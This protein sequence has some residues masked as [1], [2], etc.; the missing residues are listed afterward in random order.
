MAVRS[1][2]LRFSTKNK[3]IRTI[4]KAS[5]AIACEL[6]EDRR[7]LT[8]LGVNL[9]GDFPQVLVGGGGQ[10]QYQSTTFTLNAQDLSL[11]EGIAFGPSG[12]ALVTDPI[13]ADATGSNASLLKIT[14]ISDPTIS[15]P[16]GGLLTGGVPVDPAGDN[17]IIQGH[18][19]TQLGVSTYDGVLLT[20]KIK[21]F[22]SNFTDSSAG[23][24]MG[25]FDFRFEAT[26]GLLYSRYFAGKDIG[27]TL[28]AGDKAVG[29]TYPASGFGSGFISNVP[30]A[31][32]AP[33]TP[34]NTPPAAAIHL[35]KLTNGTDNDSPT[36]PHVPVGST[37]TW[38]YVVTNTGSVPLTNINVTDDHFGVTPVYVGG[39]SNNNSI[40]DLTETWTYRATGIAIAG[41]YRNV[42]TVTGTIP[43]TNGQTVTSNNPDHYF[44]DL[45]K[46]KI[47]K[48]TNDT[49]NDSPTGPYISVGSPVT[50][51]YNVTNPGNVP[52]VNVNVTDSIAGV[53][54]TPTL[55]GGFNVGDTNADNRLDVGE[56][57]VYTA[58][59]VATAGQYG[60]VGTATGDDFFIPT[61]HVTDQ[62][63]DH[64]YGYL[65]VTI[66]DFVW[67]DSNANGIQDSGEPGI[68][69]VTLTLTG[70]D[71]QGNVVT[72]TA[73]T[74]G[75][76][77]YTFIE[78]PG[79]YTV[80]VDASNFTGAGALAGYI[81]SPTLQGGNPA[82]DSNPNPSG[83]T[84]L[85]FPL[86][87]GGS[88]LTIDFGYYN[89]VTI[90]NFVWN[91]LNGNGIQNPGEPGIPGVTLTL[92]GTTGSGASVTQTT[93][94]DANG[95]YQFTEPPG[96][97]TVSVTTPAGYLPT[98]T[99]Q[100]TPATDSNTTPSGT[101]P[102]TLPSG[103][104]DQTID[105]G[106]F[107]VAPAIHIVKLTNSTD[108]DATTGPFVP[109][110]STVTWT[111]N[112]TNT[113][114]V[115]LSNVVVTDD[116]GTPGNTG[117]D[118]IVGV[119][120][121]LPIGGSASLTHQGTA[122]A[123]QYG[124]VGTVTGTPVDKNGNPIPGTT[125]PTDTNPDHYFAYTTDVH[126]IKLTNGTDNDTGTGPFVPVGS[127]VTWTY[128][129]TTTGNVPL[130]NV[131]VT[132]NVAGVNP[133]PSLSGGF[134]TGDTN[135]DNLLESGETWVFTASGIAVAGQYGNVGTVTGTPVTPTG[136][137][138]PGA[139]TQTDTNPDHYFGAT[140]SIAL[141]KL[142]NGTNN[143]TG[144]GPLVPAGSTVTWTYNVTNTGNVTLVNVVVTDDNGTP[145]NTADDFTVGTIASLAPGGSASLNHSG[146]ALLG[147]YGNVGSVIGTPVDNN[148]HTIPGTT[149]PTDTNPD[150]YFAYTTNINIVKLTNGSNNDTA[151]GLYVQA[152]SP[153]TWTYNVTTTG[154]VP[155][156]NVNVTDN[157]AGV[158]PAPV[159][160]GGFNVGD[161]NHDSL[162]EIGE[163]WVFTASGT[164]I[165]GQY[166]N[167][168]TVTGTPSDTSGNPI[169][170]ASTQTATNPDNYFGA[171]P[172][173]ALVKLTNGTN[174]DTGTGPLVPVGSTVTWTYNV[175]NTGNVTLANVVV[176]DDNGTPGNTADDFT[177]G[178][179]ASLAP[180][181]SASL[182]HTGIAVAGQ[183][184]NVG[185]VIGTPVDNNGHTI[186]GTTPP[187][188]TNPDH[189][190][191][192]SPITIGDFVWVD[193]NA[194]GVQDAGE[195]GINGV[196]L[197][198]TGTDFLGNPVTD[199]RTTAGNGA[200]LFTE[201]PGTY[202]VTV[203]TANF[204]GA[205]ALTGYTATATGQ[206]T[207]A[208]DSNPNP[209]ATTPGT[210]LLPGG[211][212]DLTIDFGFY[213]PVTIGNFVWND[214]NGNG[215]QDT[216]E[217]GIPGVTLTLTGTTGSGQSVTQTTTT[218]ANGLYQFTEPPGTYTVAV[219]APSGY[220][221]TVTGQGTTAI[222]SNPSPSGTTP[223]T[224]P[225][226]GTDQTID[227]GFYKPVTIGDFVWN[228]TN[229][230]GV[231]DGGEA[232]IP[233]VTLTLTGTTGA[234]VGVSQTTTTDASGHYLFTEPPGT[235]TVAVT[236]PAGYTPTAS[237]KGT[238]ATD[239]NPT[240]SGTTPGTLPGGSSDLTI[241]FGFYQ[242]VTIGNFVW[243]DANGNGVQDAGEPGI[244]GVTLTLIGTT[245]SGQSVSQTTT[246]DANGLYQFTE[247]PGTYSVA[248]TAP[249]GYTP[250]VTGKGTTATDSNPTPSGTTPGTLP[251]GGTDQTIDFGFYKPVTIGD[252]VW[253]DTNGNGVQD[254][255]EAGIPGVTLT[256]T[257][258]TGAGA[259]V[260]QTTTIGAAGQYL[261][262]E[263]P[264]T[265]TVTVT[266]PAGYTPTATGK[267]TTATD[268]NTNPSSTTP[269]T[270]P[271][272]SSDL[273]VDFGF[274]KPVTIGDFVWTDTNANGIQDSGEAGINGVTLTLTGT[275]GAGVAVTDHA[276]TSG[277]GGYL[278]TEAPGTY[279][280]TVDASNFATGGALAGYFV[281]PTLAGT[282]RAVDSNVSPSG[283]TP[284]ALPGG[285][286]D[287]T[288]DF[289]YYKQFA[290]GI[291]TTVGIIT[292]IPA[293]IPGEFA[294][295]GFW[296][297]QN[298]QAVIKSFNGSSTSTLLGNWLA[299][300]FPHLFGASNP[301]TGTSL[302]GLTNA[303]VAQVYLNLWTPSGVT[304][305]TYVQ[306]F[307][308]ALGLY[309]DTT[310]LG[311][312]SLLNNGLA[313]QFGFVVTTSGAGSFN[314]GSNGV[315]FGVSNGSSLS[316]MQVLQI[317]DA[318]FS[319]STGL[320]FAG[321]QTKTSQFNNVTNGINSLGDIP[322]T[323]TT[324]TLTG[325]KLIDSATISGGLNPTGTV[326]FYLMAPGSTASTPLSSAV[327]TDVVTVN[328]NGTYSVAS[329]SS[330]YVPTVSGTYQWVAIYSGDAN[331]Q[332]ITSPFGSEPQTVGN[333]TTTINTIPGSAVTLGSG[334]K[335][336]DTAAL[337]AGVNA[338]GTITFYLFA[339]GVTP[340][341]TDSNNVYSDVVTVNG[342]GTYTTAAGTN[343]GGYLPTVAGTYQ[344]IAV[345]SGDANNASAS[346]NF[347][348]E[349]EVASA[350]L[351]S[352]SGNVYCDNNLNGIR[353]TGEAAEPGTVV[354]LYNG[355][356]LVATKTT[357]SSG[358]YSFTG[359][360]PGTYTVK[361]TTPSSGDVV[362]LSHGTVVI[363][364]SYTVTLAP[365]GTTS[366]G[367]NFAEIDYGSISGMIFLDNNDNAM[368]DTGDT[369]IAGATVT[370]TGTDYLGNP[371]SIPQTTSSSG[372]FSFINLLPSN[373]AGYT[374]QTTPPAGF[375]IGSDTPGTL[376]GVTTGI[377][378]CDTDG[379]V[380]NIVLPGCN[381]DAVNYN[382]GEL[383]IFHGLTA[384]IG[385]W[386]NANG[387][388][389]IKSFGTTSSGLTLANLLATNMPNL[390]GKNAP[391]WNVNSTIGTNLTGRSNTDVANY[392]L[393][394]FGVSGQKSYAQILATAFAVF[395]TTNSLNTG[396]TSRALATK[397]GFTLSNTGAGA[398]T[399]TVPQAD[400]AAFGITSSAGATQSISQL[401]LLANKYAIKGVLNNGNTTLITETSDVFNAINNLGDIG[402][403]M[404]LISSGT[405]G[406]VMTDSIGHL[407][408]GTYLVAVDGLSGDLAPAEQARIDDAI[409]NLN[410]S[411]A[412]FGVLLAEAPADLVAS[413]DIH[414][415]L[416]DTSV[417]GGLDQGVLGVTQTGGNIT[418]ING[419]N[420][421]VD[422]NAS[423]IEAN[424]FDF[425][426]V[427]THEM[428]HALGLGHSNDAGSVM[429]PE[430]GT[431]EA[432]RDLTSSDLAAIDNDG[433]EA[434]QALHAI[435]FSVKSPVALAPIKTKKAAKPQMAQRPVFAARPISQPKT[436]GSSNLAGLFS[437]TLVSTITSAK[438]PVWNA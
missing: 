149:P 2:N 84:P 207:T 112:V 421:Y 119:I 33:L 420:Y 135:H 256:L 429:Y 336:T 308:N 160:S 216:G 341:A 342:N 401:T 403:G 409:A 394:I 316:V 208:T 386:H 78:N 81:A 171:T 254:S 164:A 390:F 366:T 188:D 438:D 324:L 352:I 86:P 408:A 398:A 54:P 126:I 255:G 213:K 12:P 322:G 195:P 198:L 288:I 219:T 319:A 187:T 303:Q 345:Y 404:A 295:I 21:A 251:S 395:T 45:P 306:A 263:P 284:A 326:T 396:A 250:T 105:F 60:N 153:V 141:V 122:V 214:S 377:D 413:A 145:G 40:L 156:S 197:T 391:G 393:T 191:A 93:T 176:T 38:D 359:V 97:Y 70:T 411:A 226:G 425:Q 392:F 114:N 354:S 245:G 240:P 414:I 181:A 268:S 104:S 134:N 397:Y 101:T 41:Q 265:Y 231:Q 95:L 109:V 325:M 300:S 269:G 117:D 209:S 331:N 273:T 314:I 292:G 317:V 124:N 258:T 8:L 340:N 433:E 339:P 180:G 312:Q 28:D 333:A 318:N 7:L 305:N 39:D 64:Y 121:S 14:V 261:F 169:P 374:V 286:S 1:Q 205:G 373:S 166:S 178:T 210:F 212:S 361:V 215:V 17:L 235:Y 13:T 297:N 388:S 193:T 344:W 146:I 189:Y 99:G 185:S 125:P 337:A 137:V 162:L 246:T 410:T 387:Q 167:I 431:G 405:G 206:G 382:F 170:G 228:D 249:A 62:N 282:N 236:T 138:I 25:H 179:V 330:G 320:F 203:D 376:N 416:S 129:V 243:N 434:P 120:P 277:N 329:N 65:P 91:D 285:S 139:T 225:S 357:D 259:S 260:T 266:P 389:L 123:G 68:Q 175:T 307:A 3:R 23:H 116:N 283:T 241:D 161:S 83:T 234:G 302:A 103:G 355:T 132:D 79:T 267:G 174:N 415:H 163:T 56:M 436:G 227:F 96:T 154:N 384:T 223:G 407:Y 432:R 370:L 229:G 43:N 315:A 309:A 230:N 37:V 332:S 278:F 82:R 100:G 253:N 108:N 350:A 5:N 402:I 368:V 422:A 400:W 36:G 274:Y 49:E 73:T 287:L 155:L 349:P 106:F 237:G 360:A 133:T 328:G 30:K 353:D 32:I 127:T 172:S 29:D 419:W 270:L 55:S 182:T 52:L 113:G 42:G 57:W 381:N 293:V 192:Y 177:V 423:G 272:A 67:L 310:S 294:T 118:F 4:S 168:G 128:N 417:I 150:H 383:G 335:L 367:N 242:P 152:G 426:T 371:V 63:P 362:E 338:T 313:A 107:A 291:T 9:T 418:I 190:Y 75:I 74:T 348:D 76:G 77:A 111:Y 102:L 66:G 199:H 88:D 183:Y 80:T 378:S 131:A 11:V 244:P 275:N 233:G 51:T 148:G 69:D 281:S 211:G 347:G 19:T 94:T 24:S 427:V 346:D 364:P 53:N 321:D 196:T 16:R 15:D 34:V 151:P 218:D 276:T 194:N 264:G 430:L 22:G 365:T 58:S 428:G 247:P 50:W 44:G 46:I 10:V 27:M 158:N 252:F 301:Y 369:G 159:L 202:T 435:P 98:L 279:T 47:D 222:D 224:L 89:P 110:G 48:L 147:Q 31:T 262:T 221:P 363:A 72:E 184:G 71:F 299:T 238:T 173:I 200:Y 26:G 201:N 406:A 92:T 412:R 144:T 87:G 257:G 343:P 289:G 372:L 290:P 437:N 375:V 217:P 379:K 204:S 239:S 143:D 35:V 380:T 85:T 323:G 304:K 334:V 327:Y 232:G 6:L 248:V 186:P 271:G 358:N 61:I 356:T 130:G 351:S 90:G 165:V 18:V 140:P 296:H 220:V 280:V 385:F 59:G 142:T 298:G 311:G 424:Q 399:Y 115:A 20:G 157:I 136:G